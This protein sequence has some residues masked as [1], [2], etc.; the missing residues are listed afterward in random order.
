[1]SPTKHQV[2]RLEICGLK[3]TTTTT[4]YHVKRLSPDLGHSYNTTWIQRLEEF[5]WD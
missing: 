1:M 4:K 3:T 2:S 5:G